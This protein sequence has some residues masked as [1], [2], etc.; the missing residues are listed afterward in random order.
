LKNAANALFTGFFLWCREPES[1]WRHQVF[2]TCALPTE[3][4]RQVLFHQGLCFVS[5]PL[6]GDWPTFGP[7]GSSETALRE[8]DA[9]GSPAGFDAL[10]QAVHRQRRSILRPLNRVSVDRECNS[11]VRV[12]E[13]LGDRRR[14][15]AALDQQRG[16]RMA[17]VVEPEMPDASSLGKPAEEGRDRSRLPRLANRIGED[18]SEVSISRTGG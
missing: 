10:Q 13:H 12:S 1:N 4:S 14:R 15:H 18:Q 5:V 11:R 17:Q 8:A 3:L 9:W 2:Q 7:H 16:S 6:G